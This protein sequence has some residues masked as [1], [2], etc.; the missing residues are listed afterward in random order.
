MKI[1]YYRYHFYHSKTGKGH[2]SVKD[3]T[4]GQSVQVF[5]DSIECHSWSRFLDSELNWDH[6][7]ILPKSG[8]VVSVDGTHQG[9][10]QTDDKG[11]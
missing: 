6:V 5:M 8:E 3:T 4:K 11:N 10:F 1:E 7:C 9:N 2:F